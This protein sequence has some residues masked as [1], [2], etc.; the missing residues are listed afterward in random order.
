MG[1]GATLLNDFI[2]EEEA[3]T[4]LKASAI[5]AGGGDNGL[6]GDG[7]ALR[8]PDRFLLFGPLCIPHLPP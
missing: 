5:D 8:R 3:E 6:R 2:P 1:A 4:E 7:G